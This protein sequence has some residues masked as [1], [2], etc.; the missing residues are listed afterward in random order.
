MKTDE[1]EDRYIA[2]KKHRLEFMSYLRPLL[3]EQI[4]DGTG[5]EFLTMHVM[6]NPQMFSKILVERDRLES[7]AEE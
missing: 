7:I 5:W 3:K 6:D 2:H 1:E 4:D